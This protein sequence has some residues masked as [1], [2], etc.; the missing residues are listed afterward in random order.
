MSGHFNF[1]R[2][3]NTPSAGYS[4]SYSHVDWV[5]LGKTDISDLSRR[6]STMYTID[7]Y[8]IA[9]Y[10]CDQLDLNVHQNHPTSA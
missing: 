4:C 2:D 10:S 3:M 1:K 7:I 8:G 6:S 9:D 5:F